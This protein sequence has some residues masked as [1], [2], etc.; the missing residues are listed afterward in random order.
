MN[1]RPK[2]RNKDQTQDQNAFQLNSRQS[3]NYLSGRVVSMIRANDQSGEFSTQ[4]LIQ[5]E[6]LLRDEFQTNQWLLNVCKAFT[7]ESVF[8]TKEE[9]EMY[10]NLF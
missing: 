8:V 6:S 10:F 5:I 3:R 9:L 2:Q 7:D 4:E 1:V